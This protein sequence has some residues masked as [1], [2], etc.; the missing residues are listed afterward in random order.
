MDSQDFHFYGRPA[1]VLIE[2]DLGRGKKATVEITDLCTFAGD[3]RQKYGGISEIRIPIRGPIIERFGR[4]DD[5]ARF[6]G[7]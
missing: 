3:Y 4:T 6:A 2:M 7:L 1:K 5:A